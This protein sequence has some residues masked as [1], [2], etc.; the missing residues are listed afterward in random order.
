MPGLGN[1][2]YFTHKARVFKPSG[3][4]LFSYRLLGPSLTQR[5]KDAEKQR[6]MNYD[7]IAFIVW[8]AEV[9]KDR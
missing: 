1:R 5:R 7:F 3:C 8:H 9:L 4:F 2:A 6:N